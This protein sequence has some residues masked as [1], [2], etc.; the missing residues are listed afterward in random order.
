MFGSDWP[1]CELAAS[2][3]D[4]FDALTDCIGGVSVHERERILGQ[5][6]ID[7]YRLEI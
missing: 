7:F 1:V 2:Y 6:A 3:Q 5:N 4:V